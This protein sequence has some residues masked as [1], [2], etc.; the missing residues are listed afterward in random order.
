MDRVD[1]DKLIYV[2]SIDDWDTIEVLDDKG[3]VIRQY[4]LLNDSESGS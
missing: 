3:R 2:I 4:I 1:V